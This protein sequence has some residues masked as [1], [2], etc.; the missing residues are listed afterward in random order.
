[1]SGQRHICVWSGKRGGYGALAPTMKAI[2][3]HPAMRLSV[4]VTDQHLYPRFG[5]T[6][7]EVQQEFPIA[8][9][10]DM[11]QDGDSNRARGRAVGTCLAKSVDVL[12]DLAPDVLVVIGDRGEVLAATIAA[13]NL[14]IPIA[15]IQGGDVSGSLDEPVRH[16]VTKLAH[17]HFASTEASARR[18]VAMG[19]EP[20]RVHVVGDTHIDR[21][22]MG[23][24]TPPD[25][26]RARYAL[27]DAG[28]FLIV[29]QHPDSADAGS[30]RAQMAETVQA[31]LSFG[32]RT[33]LVYPCS[34][35]GFEGIIAEIEAVR[36]VPG[37]SVHRNIPARDFTG[38]QAIAGCL[39]GNS[40][41]GLIEAPYF[42]LPAVNVGDRQQGREHAGNVLH[43]PYERSRIRAAIATALSDETF[44]ARCRTLRPPFGD[45]TAYQRISSVLAEVALDDHLLTKRM[46]Y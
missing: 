25:V 13:H 4:V 3:G 44:R 21:I 45:G 43:V 6:I 14:R 28:P 22:L 20:W 30:S 23:E 37:V 10:I 41:A 16:A 39:V 29:L 11:E 2:D 7:E 8:A 27:P 33:L 24:V 31:V 42:A 19:E 36:D 46:T 18:I 17:L 26:L 32:L 5:R 9:A 34:D 35:Q 40:S 15:H 12:A 38:L 1:V